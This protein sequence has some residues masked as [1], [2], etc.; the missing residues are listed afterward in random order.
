MS[1]TDTEAQTLALLLSQMRPDWNPAGVLSLIK[2]NRDHHQF[3]ALARAAVNAATNPNNR[4]PAVI[5]MPG[6]HW[7]DPNTMNAAQRRMQQGFEAMAGYT[8]RA[9]DPWTRKAIEA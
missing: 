8:G 6:S 7:A 3:P 9:E 2:K 1:I 4:T 5:F